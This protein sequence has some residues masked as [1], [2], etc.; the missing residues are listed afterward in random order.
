M[1]PEPLGMVGI[2]ERIAFLIHSMPSL[3]TP[4]PSEQLA[5]LNNHLVVVEVERQRAFLMV[6][7]AGE[8][9][10]IIDNDRRQDAV[11]VRVVIV[12]R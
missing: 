10:K 8:I 2:E 6:A 9:V 1:A 12:E 11:D 3:G 4:K 5:L 7:G